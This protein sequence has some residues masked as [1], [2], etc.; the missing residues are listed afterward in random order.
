MSCLMRQY[1]IMRPP[2]HINRP[3]RDVGANDDAIFPRAPRLAHNGLGPRS[4]SHNTR[5]ANHRRITCK[6]LVP[7]HHSTSG[8]AEKLERQQTRSL[9]ED[10]RKPELYAMQRF[11]CVLRRDLSVVRDTITEPWSDSQTEGQIN[12]LNPHLHKIRLL[13]HHE[14][15]AFRVPHNVS[16]IRTEKIR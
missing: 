4:D 15:R 2:T 9:D 11:A 13:P 3:I 10:A 1:P 16:R 12:R 7:A 14:H 6:A 5:A 8:R